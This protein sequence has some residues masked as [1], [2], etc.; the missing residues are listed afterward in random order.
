MEINE[1]DLHQLLGLLQKLVE[2]NLSAKTHKS[3]DKAIDEENTDLTDN[4]EDLTQDD[5]EDEEY[6]NPVIKN[7][8]SKNVVKKN[9]FV[10]KFLEMK[11]AGMHKSDTEIDKKLNKYPPTQRNR[12]YEPVKVKCRVCGK[13]ES[14]HPSIVESRDRYKCN[15]CSTSQG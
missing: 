3:N 11:E 9:K 2:T 13:T 1:K 8:K 5:N 7:K 15:N 6:I 4:D 12:A 14:V 10:N